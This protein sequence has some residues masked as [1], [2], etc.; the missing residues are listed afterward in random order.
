[1]SNF[2]LI[3]IG[4]FVAGAIGGLLVFSGIINVGGSSATTV[5]GSATVWGTLDDTAFSAF[6]TSFNNSSKDVHVTYVQKDPA[7]LDS[8]LTEALASGTPPD[9]VLLPDNLVWRYQDKLI[10]IPFSTLPTATFQTTFVDS[11]DIFL[12]SDGTVALPFAADPL[13]MYYNKDLLASAGIAQPPTNWQ[14]FLNSIPLMTKKKS[15]L[16]LTQMG[17]AMGAYT[18][19]AHAKDILAM[20]FM[21]SG[22]QFI[23]DTGGMLDVHFGSNAQGNEEADAASAMNFYMGFSDPLKQDYT[24]NAGSPLDRDA[25]TQSSLAYYFGSA[26]ELPLIRAQN[27]NLNFGIALPP[28]GV[29]GTPLTTGTSYG[30]AIPKTAPNEL[31]SYTAATLMISAASE[32]SLVN[33]TGTTLALIPTRRDVLTIK[34]TSDPYLQFLY[35]A[36]LVQHSWL[37]PN[38]TVSDQ[39]F[40]DLVKNISSSTFD[41]D[42]ALTQA[43]A[44]LQTLNAK[45]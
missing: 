13:V 33:T 6:L 14:D 43:S 23:T 31:L 38:P 4:I 39:I 26:S 18:N 17:A 19:I 20:L 2:K 44:Q 15:D 34:P 36:A 8:D 37:D 16:T 40:G 10:H 3:F 32:T 45:I 11:A 25:F 12:A 7:T 27:P 24:W 28:Q 35:N 41:T 9:L 5:Q 22:S 42:S 30:F 1:M 29:S 21:Q